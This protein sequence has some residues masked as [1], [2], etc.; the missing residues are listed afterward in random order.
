MLDSSQP[1]PRPSHEAHPGE[2]EYHA[3]IAVHLILTIVT[4]GLF[5]LYW[6]YKQMQACNQMLGRREFSFGL[7]FL[8][9]FITCGIYHVFYQYKVG[10]A[11]VELQRSRDRHVFGELPILS[12]IVTIFA[13]SIIVDAIHQ[14][15]INKLVD[16]TRQ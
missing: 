7:W 2:S 4:C 15:E 3:N 14:S 10:M 12:V 11:I 1:S 5:S 9:T 6:N 8:L 13:L 16:P